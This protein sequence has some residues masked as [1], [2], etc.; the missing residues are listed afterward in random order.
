MMLR[1]TH[2]FFVIFVSIT[3]VMS[4]LPIAVASRSEDAAAKMQ[5]T[6]VA[7][8]LPMKAAENAGSEIAVEDAETGNMQ[9]TE[10]ATRNRHAEVAAEKAVVGADVVSEIGESSEREAAAAQQIM[11]G[12]VEL[13][14]AAGNTSHLTLEREPIAYLEGPVWQDLQLLTSFVVGI[15]LVWS[16]ERFSQNEDSSAEQTGSALRK[17]LELYPLIG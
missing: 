9:Q 5:Q 3:F 8:Q 6:E 7:S 14:A 16:A 12:A 10:A 4:I 15:M 1:S 11:E 13:E 17:R 2:T